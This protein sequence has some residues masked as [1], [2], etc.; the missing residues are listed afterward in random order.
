MKFCASKSSLEINLELSGV[1]TSS[2]KTHSPLEFTN[3]SNLV[4]TTMI[5]LF[6]ANIVKSLN[7]FFFFFKI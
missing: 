2:P 4:S 5:P 1:K 7:R 3:I 6:S